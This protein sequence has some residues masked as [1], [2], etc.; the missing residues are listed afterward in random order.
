VPVSFALLASARSREQL[1]VAAAL[2]G[3]GLGAAFPAFMTFVVTHT[4]EARRART[5][6]SVIWAFDTGIGLGSLAIGAISEWRGL[7]FAFGVAAGI[8]CL[9]IPIFRA[10][11]AR[12]IRGTPVAENAG[13]A[14]TG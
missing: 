9:A 4:D 14:G 7:G 1:I 8:A 12:L 13:H 11:S 10:T 5:F 6:G 2:F 3:I